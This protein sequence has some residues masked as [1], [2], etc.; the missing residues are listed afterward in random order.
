MHT[1]LYIAFCSAFG[2][3]EVRKG[4]FATT[5]FVIPISYIRAL[6][7]EAMSHDSGLKGVMNLASDRTLTQT[8]DLRPL[9]WF[10]S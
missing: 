7:C 5:H 9:L 4:Q 8:E 1:Y 6:S 2:A 10:G 3:A